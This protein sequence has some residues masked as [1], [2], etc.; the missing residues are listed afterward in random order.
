MPSVVSDAR[1]IMEALEGALGSADE[2]LK[3]LQGFTGPLGERG[4][5]IVDSIEGGVDS[6]K[7][8]RDR[9]GGAHAVTICD[10]LSLERF[11]ILP[12]G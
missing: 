2:N 7:A 5:E 10:I 9:H 6:Q 12:N 4:P 3:N 8:P 1:V 11:Q